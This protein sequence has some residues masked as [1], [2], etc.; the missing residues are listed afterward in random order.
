[1]IKKLLLLP[2]GFIAC[3]SLFG[4]NN[5][6]DSSSEQG[7]SDQITSSFDTSKNIK[8]YTRNTSSGTRDGFFTALGW[9]EAIKS[10]AVLVES[11][12]IVTGNG[13]M[14]TK[15]Q[16]DEYGIGYIS[17]SSLEGSNLKGLDFEGVEPTEENVINGSYTLSRNFNYILRQDSDMSENEQDLVYSF[18]KYINTV[19]GASII[20]GQD[21]ILTNIPDK[22]WS[23]V[24]A[25]DA[26]V[27][28]TVEKTGS[29]TMINL[30]GST[31]VQNVAKALAEAFEEVC[32]T[33]AFKQNHTGSGDAYSRTQGDEKNGVNKLHIGFLS[34][35]IELEGSE[36]AVAGTYGTICKDGIVAVVNAENTLESVT[37]MDL[38][39]MYDGTFSTWSQIIE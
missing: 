28:A 5:N 31:S 6:Q 3:L 33:F 17:L 4:C 34:R 23:E 1:M 25:S 38:R 14:I 30:G 26:R 21:G 19:E 24:I 27:K 20:G 12:A 2:L 16:N 35:E 18:L 22:T 32:P 36:P 29:K 7:S 13:D 39:K 10:D 9:K 11:K 8:V 37:A 15:I